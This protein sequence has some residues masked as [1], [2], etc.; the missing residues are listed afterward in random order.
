M[1][2]LWVTS[3]NAH[4]CVGD[5]TFTWSWVL[6]YKY[7]SI[8]TFTKPK[9]SSFSPVPPFFSIC[10]C[11]LHYVMPRS[12]DQSYTQGRYITLTYQWHKVVALSLS[13]PNFIRGWRINSKEEREWSCVSSKRIL[14]NLLHISPCMYYR[15]NISVLEFLEHFFLQYLELHSYKL[16]CT[17][18]VRTH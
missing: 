12:I 6:C 2:C 1:R 14:Q 11:R 16:Q 4:F 3:H 5:I 10:Q 15:G 13:T 17:T 8:A 9:S 7:S 18:S